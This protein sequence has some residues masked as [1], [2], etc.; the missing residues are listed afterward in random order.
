MLGSSSARATWK[1]RLGIPAPHQV[2]QLIE[3]LTDPWIGGLDLF[4]GSSDFTSS[5]QNRRD[6]FTGSPQ[7][8]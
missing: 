7:G 8:T 1:V 5:L 6:K 2:S 4:R 3:G